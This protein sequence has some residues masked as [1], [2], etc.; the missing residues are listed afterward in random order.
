MRWPS[1]SYVFAVDDPDSG[2][3]LWFGLRVIRRAS[4]A[5]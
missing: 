3:T 5:G 4:A 1:G 2:R